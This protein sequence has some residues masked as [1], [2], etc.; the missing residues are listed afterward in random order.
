MPLERKL[1]IRHKHMAHPAGLE[2]YGDEL[3]VLEQKS[4]SLLRFDARSGRF[5]GVALANLPDDPEQL[6][7]VDDEC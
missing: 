3:L 6:L 2:L 4:R 5:L 7:V 1:A